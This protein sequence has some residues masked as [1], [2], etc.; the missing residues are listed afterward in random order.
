MLSKKRIVKN[1]KLYIFIFFFTF[2]EFFNQF[3]EVDMCVLKTKNSGESRGFAF[4]RFK[5][6]SVEKKVD[7]IPEHCFIKHYYGRENS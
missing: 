5:D 7:L 4:I 1:R 3:G 2:R 6:K